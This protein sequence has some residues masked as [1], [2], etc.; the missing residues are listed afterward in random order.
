MKR[1]IFLFHMGTLLAALLFL[2]V[3]NGLVLHMH[4]SP[5]PERT[6]CNHGKQ[7]VVLPLV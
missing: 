3:F 6:R 4:R 2:L 1:Q 7:P 5:I